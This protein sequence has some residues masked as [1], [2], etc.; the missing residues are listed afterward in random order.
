MVSWGAGVC[1]AVE[2]VPAVARADAAPGCTEAMFT[3]GGLPEQRSRV[4][5]GELAEPG[6]DGTLHYVAH[7]ARRDVEDTGLLRRID[8][9]TSS[10]APAMLRVS[11]SQ[12]LTPDDP[13][14]SAVAVPRSTRR[15]TA[16][17]IFGR[18]G[19]LAE[20]PDSPCRSPARSCHAAPAPVP[21]L[22]NVV[23]NIPGGI[24]HE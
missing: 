18:W 21:P 1:T 3:Q 5:R 20:P 7:G 6:L 14:A 12:G 13:V 15:F 24:S 8:D 4:A 23:L 17:L 19:S 10:G 9:V 11:V 16:F 2:K 22:A